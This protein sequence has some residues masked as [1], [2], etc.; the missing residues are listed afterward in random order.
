MLK[1]YLLTYCDVASNYG[2][3]DLPA[4]VRSC[5]MYKGIVLY[6]C[7]RSDMDAVDIT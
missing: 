7:S 4:D 6:I 5:N 2:W 1:R 3:E